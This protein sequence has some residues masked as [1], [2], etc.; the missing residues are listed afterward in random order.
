M[1]LT[2][3]HIVGVYLCVQLAD[4]IKCVFG[5]IL[6]KKGVWINNMVQ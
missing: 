3:L 4:F 5:H 1:N 2:G 6:V